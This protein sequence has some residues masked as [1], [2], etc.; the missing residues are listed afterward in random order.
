MLGPELGPGVS[1]RQS[2][3]G[4]QLAGGGGSRGE[5]VVTLGRWRKR[6][7]GGTLTLRGSWMKKSR[8]RS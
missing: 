7:C 1:G 3:E 2:F 5:E 8:G 4:H 6:S